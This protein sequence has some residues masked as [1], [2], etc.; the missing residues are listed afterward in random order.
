MIFAVIIWNLLDVFGLIRLYINVFACVFENIIK[1]VATCK[2]LN[3][4]DSAYAN[5]KMDNEMEIISYI[6]K[7]SHNYETDSR[8]WVMTFQTNWLQTKTVKKSI[9]FL[10]Q[11]FFS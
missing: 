9:Q 6:F 11:S 8:G 10:D 4:R 7:R 3:I 1:G 2:M 5:I